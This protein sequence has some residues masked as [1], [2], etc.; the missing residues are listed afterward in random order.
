VVAAYV[1][2]VSVVIAFVQALLLTPPAKRIHAKYFGSQSEPVIPL[3]HAPEGAKDR[4]QAHI[5]AHGGG[6]IFTC[7]VARMLASLALMGL[8]VVSTLRDRTFSDGNIAL[9]SVIVRLLS[10]PELRIVT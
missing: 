7:Q 3:G 8:V 9:I 6:I 5:K 2:A 4:L 10:Y 1:A